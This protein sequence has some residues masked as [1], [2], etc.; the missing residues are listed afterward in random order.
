ME[1]PL[2]LEWIGDAGS[3][4]MSHIAAS[5]AKKVSVRKAEP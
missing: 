3:F 4:S 5:S 2:R 1:L